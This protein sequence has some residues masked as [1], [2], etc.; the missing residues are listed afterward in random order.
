MYHAVGGLTAADDDPLN[1]GVDDE[2][3]AHGAG[4]GVPQQLAGLGVST[5]EIEGRT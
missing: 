5:G 1:A 3:T 2:A 4:G